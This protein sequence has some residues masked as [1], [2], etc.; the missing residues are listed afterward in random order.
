MT[1]LHLVPRTAVPT[2]PSPRDSPK[3]RTVGGATVLGA[4]VPVAHRA[5]APVLVLLERFPAADLAAAISPAGHQIGQVALSA[6][7]AV[8][9]VRGNLTAHHPDVERGV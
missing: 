3:P 8:G 6:G 4:A 1:V 7:A 9:W 2:V 5:A